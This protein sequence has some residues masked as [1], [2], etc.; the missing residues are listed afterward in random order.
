MEPETES[1]PTL[2]SHPFEQEEL[3]DQILDKEDSP[4]NIGTEPL[5]HSE[6]LDFR[7]RKQRNRQHCGRLTA[8][9]DSDEE[10][11]VSEPESSSMTT[12]GSES[13]NDSCDDNDENSLEAEA[14]E[15]L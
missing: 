4:S 15:G 14:P 13:S 12:P 11:E 3:E 10:M 6:S 8:S 1:A 5:S 2:N 9:E 7:P